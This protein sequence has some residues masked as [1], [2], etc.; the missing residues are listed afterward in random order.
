[1]QRWRIIVIAVIGLSCCSSTRAGAQS[2]IGIADAPSAV[3]FSGQ[4]IQKPAGPPP[5]PAHTGI[6]A[7]FK[8][9]GSDFKHLPSKENALW[10]VVGGAGALLVHPVDDDV[11]AHLTGNTTA[12][13][14]FAPGRII[15][16]TPTLLAASFTIYVIGR[17][18]DQPKVSHVGMDLIRSLVVAEAVTQT[19]KYTVR[20]E[21]PDGS[22][23]T[24]F[25]SGHAA[26][27]FAFA[28]ALERH[29][30]WKGA[31][32]AYI[33]SSY[34]AASRLNENRHFL[35]DVVFGSAVGIIAGRTVTR[36]GRDYYTASAQFVP[37]GAALI[38]VRRHAD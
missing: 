25:P 31:V 24:S 13:K 11:N 18:K 22:G 23:A 20:R 27:T 6:K 10:A 4:G 12:D 29:L 34:V 14:I 15:G 5:T 28:T 17:S 8:G 21:R 7:M 38:F 37:G 26:D 35:S 1:M 3:A 2:E 33:F 36:H 32:P 9:L 16:A 30:G 19:L